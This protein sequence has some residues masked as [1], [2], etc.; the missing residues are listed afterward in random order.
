M[1]KLFFFIQGFVLHLSCYFLYQLLL[2][3]CDVFVFVFMILW[4]ELFCLGANSSHAAL[5]VG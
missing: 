1:V 3:F 2:R 4:S 5:S